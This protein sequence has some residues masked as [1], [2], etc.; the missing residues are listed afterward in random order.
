MGRY[1]E[2]SLCAGKATREWPNYAGG[3]VI[4]AVS[5]ALAGR[6]L[7][8]QETTDRLNNLKTAWRLSNLKEMDVAASPTRGFGQV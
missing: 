5:Y 8:A 2:A 7:E 3:L 6:L 4:C 1:D